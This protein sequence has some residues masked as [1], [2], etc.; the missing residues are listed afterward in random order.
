[1]KTALN[2]GQATETEGGEVGGKDGTDHGGQF[3]GLSSISAS[4]ARNA[5]TPGYEDV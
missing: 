5:S 1:M 2:E 3:P 4:W